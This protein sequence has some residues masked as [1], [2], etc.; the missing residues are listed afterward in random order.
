[1]TLVIITT[2]FET[3]KY[4]SQCQQTMH[5]MKMNFETDTELSSCRKKVKQNNPCYL[6]KSQ[7][8]IRY[9]TNKTNSYFDD[10]RN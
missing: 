4:S 3:K 1:M 2:L 5:E 10:Y 8:G 7:A 9:Q 6:Q